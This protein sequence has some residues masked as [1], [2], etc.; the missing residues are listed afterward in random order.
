MGR[1]HVVWSR[2][3]D[4]PW[5]AI[6]IP[7]LVVEVPPSPGP[8]P[9]LAMTRPIDGGLS[10]LSGDLGIPAGSDSESD[11]GWIVRRADGDRSGSR[12]R[13]RRAIARAHRAEALKPTPRTRIAQA[14]RAPGRTRLH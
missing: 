5:I 7:G 1:G 9:P 12:D 2:T 13:L 14:V 4:L 3:S 11:P 8:T 6:A 10:G